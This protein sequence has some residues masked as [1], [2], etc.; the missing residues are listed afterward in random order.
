MYRIFNILTEFEFYLKI[1]IACVLFQQVFYVVLGNTQIDY[2]NQVLLY[3]ITGSL[4]FYGIG[5]FIERVIKGNDSLKNKLTARVSQVKEQQFPSFTVKGFFLGEV[6]SIITAC[7]VLYLAPEVHRG[8]DLILNFGWFLMR[9]VIADLCFYITHFLFH[10]KSLL[11]FHL[12]HHEFQDTSSFVAA[13]KSWAEFV[14][15]TV[16]DLLPVFIFGYD[17]NQICAWILVGNAYNLEGHSSLSIF[18]ISSDFHD[19]HHTS[20]T[21]NYGIQGFWDKMFKT[22]NPP[23]YQRRIIFPSSYLKPTE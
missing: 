11:R 4:S 3:W 12:K 17:I 19:L 15:T 5:L 16:T 23:H 21:G 18:F 22:L 20:F 13:H 7:V 8:N 14:V 10:R 1:A 6:K 9:I 2:M